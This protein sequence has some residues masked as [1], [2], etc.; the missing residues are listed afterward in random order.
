MSLDRRLLV[1]GTSSEVAKIIVW[2]IGS[3]TTIYDL[4]L[5]DVVEVRHVQMNRRDTDI[6]VLGLNKFN[7]L[8]LLYIR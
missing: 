1:V 4:L 3:R 8:Q 2:D 5:H 7:K 6:V